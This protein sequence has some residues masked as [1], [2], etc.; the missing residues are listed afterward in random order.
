M[1][2]VR[3]PYGHSMRYSEMLLNYIQ[4]P[5]VQSAFI[6]GS[7]LQ[8]FEDDELDCLCVLT[9]T[10]LLTGIPKDS[11]WVSDI[12][13][14]AKYAYTAEGHPI[15]VENETEKFFQVVQSF[16]IAVNLEAINRQGFIEIID[17]LT[18]DLSAKISF[19]V[20]EL[21]MKNKD[22]FNNYLH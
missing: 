22:T 20:T 2:R 3:N 18:L 5:Q 16:C 10:I 4:Q 1:N 9:E 7:W 21:G 6:I 12:L 14:C 19:I 17:K 8:S 15:D 11:A 13:F